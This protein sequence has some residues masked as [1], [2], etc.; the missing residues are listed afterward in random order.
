MATLESICRK[1][2]D[3]NPTTAVL[4]KRP[5]LVNMWPA[6]FF[7]LPLLNFWRD[8]DDSARDEIR[9]GCSV[10]VLREA[11]GIE[12]TAMDYCAARVMEAEDALEKQVYC[13]TAAE[14]ARHYHWLCMITDPATVAMAPDAFTRY[15]QRLVAEGTPNSQSYL[16][17]VILE[18][19]GIGH[20][21]RLAAHASTA[22]VAAVMSG[23]ARDEGLHYAAGVAQFD[24]SRLTAAD[25]QFVRGALVELCTMVGSG[26]LG[27]L[28]VVERAVGGLGQ[29]GRRSIFEKLTDPIAT[30]RRLNELAQFIARQ[31]MDGEAAWL[32]EQGFLEPL[33]AG[34]GLGYYTPP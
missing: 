19:W 29:T 33:P 20:Y 24:A 8:A 5:D 18:G 25:G 28:G 17:Q 4:G 22:D 23:I 31:G 2:V 30:A 15:L 3:R 10:T 26:P 1:L 7:R 13:L 14:E 11:L 34:V 32:A 12:R 9:H 27:V 6:E 16:L 21:Q